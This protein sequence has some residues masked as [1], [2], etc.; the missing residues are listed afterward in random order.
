M[1]DSTLGAPYIFYDL[2][3][4]PSRPVPVIDLVAPSWPKAAASAEI[5][6]WFRFTPTSPDMVLP[7][8]DLVPGI[9]RVVDIANMPRSRLRLFLTPSGE[10]DRTQLTVIEEHDASGTAEIPLLR[11]TVSPPC[12]RA[13]HSRQQNSIRVRHT[14]IIATAQGKLPAGAAC[15]VTDSR[16][17]QEGA[18]GLR[19][20]IGLPA[21]LT[22]PVPSE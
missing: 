6:T 11:V 16:R 2:D 15:T 1:A 10:K 20:Q 21:V 17:I 9:D 5:R 13:V 3:Y 4:Q 19:S 14:F 18:V 8:A 12:Q 7:L 22:V